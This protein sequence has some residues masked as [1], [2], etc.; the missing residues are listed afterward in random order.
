MSFVAHAQMSARQDD[1]CIA[2]I[3]ARWRMYG[4]LRLPWK[5]AIDLK[6]KTVFTVSASVPDYR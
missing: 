2:Q 6:G 4:Q 3:S 5:P 1:M